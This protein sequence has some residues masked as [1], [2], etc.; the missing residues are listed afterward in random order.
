MV[1]VSNDTVLGPTK[2]TNVPL[3]QAEIVNSV[4]LVLAPKNA[5]SLQHAKLTLLVVA[6]FCSS[7][8]VNAAS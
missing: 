1:E 3:C 6:R 2:V 5:G 4:I 8:L 7:K